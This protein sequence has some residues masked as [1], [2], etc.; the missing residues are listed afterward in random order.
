MQPLVQFIEVPRAGFRLQCGGVIEP[1]HMRVRSANHVVQVR[2]NAGLPALIGGM[3]NRTNLLEVCCTGGWIG[4]RQQRPDRWQFLLR[5]RRGG[6][7]FRRRALDFD[8]RF[9]GLFRM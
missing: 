6:S 3:A 2:P 9:C 1:L 5:G 4:R 8:H 7:S